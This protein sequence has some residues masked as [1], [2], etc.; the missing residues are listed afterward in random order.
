MPHHLPIY[1]QTLNIGNWKLIGLSH[2]AV[3]QYG[4]E[5]RKLWPDKH[6]SIAGYCNDVNSYLPAASHIKAQ[7][8]EG[9]NSFFWYSQPG[10]FPENILDTVVSTIKYNNR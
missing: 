8:Y 7:T 10:F 2:E 5:I 6:V 1:V 3:T 4:M 9:Y